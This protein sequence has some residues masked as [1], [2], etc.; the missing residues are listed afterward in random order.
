MAE[1]RNLVGERGFGPEP[2]ADRGPEPTTLEGALAAQLISGE[3]GAA[4]QR[5]VERLAGARADPA[6][7]AASKKASTDAFH[8]AAL[9]AAGLL[10]G[11]AAVNGIGLRSKDDE[12]VRQAS[13]QPGAAPAGARRPGA[14]V[15]AA[16][17]SP[18]SEERLGPRA[19]RAAT[20][21]ALARAV[22]SDSPAAIRRS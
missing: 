17:P 9:V 2:Y 12:R 13:L 6:L 20:D 5:Q 18:C 10:A 11:G 4:R 1:E 19:L 16:W 14:A 8:L 7:V 21:L 3:I 22:R 15:A